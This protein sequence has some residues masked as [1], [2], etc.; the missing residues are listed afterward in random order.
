MQAVTGKENN[1]FLKEVWGFFFF[2]FPFLME[3]AQSEGSPVSTL[4][5]ARRVITTPVSSRTE[6]KTEPHVKCCD[7]ASSKTHL[8]LGHLS[9]CSKPLLALPVSTTFWSKK[10]TG[11]LMTDCVLSY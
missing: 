7:T 1:T 6:G 5:S 4:V 9:S 2:L 3:L 11:K 10:N 8:Q